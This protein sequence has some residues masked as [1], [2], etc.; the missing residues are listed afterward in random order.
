MIRLSLVISTFNRSAQLL[1]T[2]ESVAAQDLDP[3]AWEC[4]VV[5]N[6]SQDDTAACFA[7]FAG[8]HRGLDLRMVRETAPGVSCARNRGIR[9]ARGEVVAIIDDDERIVPG[10]VRAYADFF[11]AHPEAEAAGGRIIAD[12]PSGRPAWMSR[13]T[14]IP[15]ANPM[16][17]GPAVRPFPAGRIPGGGNMALRRA[18]LRRYGGFDPALGRVGGRLTGGEESDLFYRL[19][20]DGVELWYLP[21]AVMWHIIPPEKLTADYFRRLSFNVG[22]SQRRRARQDGRLW[23][24]YVAEAAKWAATL[25]LC[26]TL[27]PLQAQWLLRMRRGISRGVFSPER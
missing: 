3:A 4:I 6:N 26:C 17:F 23:R 20:R 16:D 5:D 1:T 10:F 8:A 19:R 9:E 22:V 2:L 13:Y 11:A 12:Y 21:E 18:T 7:R 15:I 24:L 14:E 25:A 27:R